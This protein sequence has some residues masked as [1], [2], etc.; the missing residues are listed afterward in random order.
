[1]KI[2][3]WIIGLVVV[4]LGL[5]YSLN[6]YIY[7]EKQEDSSPLTSSPVEIIP[8]THATAV[9]KW[10]DSI[11]YTDPT[12]GPQAFSGQASP[13]II[14]ITDIHGDHLSTSTLSGVKGG[15]KII[16]P[17]AVYDLLPTEL[18]SISK[19]LNNGETIVE[20]GFNISAIPMYNLPEEATSRHTKGRG[21]GYVIEKDNFRVYVAGDTAGIPEMRNLT[22]IDIALVPMNPPY[23]MTVEEA[24]DAVLAFKPKRVYPY[25]YR[26]QNGLSDTS[27]FKQLVN[28]GDPNIEVILKNWYPS[29]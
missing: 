17:K 12:G 26:G 28:T 5:F 6:N 9:I 21:N 4:T 1:M 11:I 7:N 16:S 18:A 20:Q 27:K 8:I 29:N 2:L 13:N 3:Y 24:V 10:D 25:H 19:I 22:D 15:A 14:L 23:T